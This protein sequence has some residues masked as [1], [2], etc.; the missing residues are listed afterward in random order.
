[1]AGDVIAERY[2]LLEPLG[3]GGSWSSIWLADDLKLNR[4]VAVKTLAPAADPMRFRREARA[5]ALL[6]HPNICALHDY[7]ED[8][9][10]PFI[11]LEYLPGGSL[12]E[13]LAPGVPLADGEVYRIAAGLA[14]GLRHA[15]EHGLVHRD[16]KPAN[17]L[18]ADDRR[19]KIAD[20]GIA[21]MIDTPSVTE[22][23]TVLGTAAYISPEQASA[24]PAGKES[25]VYSFGVILFRMLT[26]RLP[27][28]SRN[29]LRSSAPPALAALVAAAL[30]KDPASRPPDGAAL[31]RELAR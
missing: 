11:V 18:F 19:P 9:R 12:E 28:T 7:G 4:R 13:S 27:F 24:V 31:A 17:V 8:G 16:L 23:G 15:H 26:G 1:M 14:A 2:R 25:D 30:V 22:V 20:F 29:A 10:T 21:R 3:R 5:V 6:A